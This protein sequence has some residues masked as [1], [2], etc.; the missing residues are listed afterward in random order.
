[1]TSPSLLR[2]TTVPADVLNGASDL[3]GD[4]R[5]VAG[6]AA[7][8][9]RRDDGWAQFAR[10]VLVGGLSSA[11]Y[12]LLFVLLD[13][14]GD[15]PANTAGSVLSSMVANELHRRLT[16][17]AGDRV[18]WWA[19]QWQGGGVALVG[20]VATS[21]ALAWLDGVTGATGVVADLALVALV[22]GAIG[23]ARFVALRWLFADRSGRA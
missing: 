1:M 23:L 11:V 7:D 13:G 2:R 20:I 4:A 9:L 21:L 5:T 10:F 19:A 16:F 3:A 22:T 15:Q 18:G 8:R 6:R 14:V 12:A 17:R